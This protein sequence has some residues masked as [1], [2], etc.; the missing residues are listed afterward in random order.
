MSGVSS[1]LFLFRNLAMDFSL[2]DYARQDDISGEGEIYVM[3]ADGSNP[4]RI[5][6][7]RPCHYLLNEWRSVPRFQYRDA[8]P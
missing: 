6:E 5:T 2:D 4:T 3:N 1:G 8:G 7:R